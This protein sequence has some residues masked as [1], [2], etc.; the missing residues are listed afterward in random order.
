[1][2]PDDP[3]P[4]HEYLERTRPEIRL[5]IDDVRLPPS[6]DWIWAKTS[7]EALFAFREFNVLEVSFDHDLGG[8][9]T[10]LNVA[11]FVEDCVL[12]AGM[13][14]P[15]W[16]VHSDNPPGRE[17]IKRAMQSAERG[18]RYDPVP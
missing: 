2:S 13:R 17:N 5:W 14:C 4:M 6:I 1:M 16:Y 12:N 9:D 15:I 10:A 7:A 18:P 11:N 3:E 8:D